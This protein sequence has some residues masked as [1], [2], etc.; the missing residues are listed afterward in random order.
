MPDHEPATEIACLEPYTDLGLDGIVDAAPAPD[1]RYEMR[2]AIQLAFVAVIQRLP[3][4]QRAVLLL[5]DV[6]G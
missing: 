5:R 3:P 1:A 2:E 6:M 4:Q